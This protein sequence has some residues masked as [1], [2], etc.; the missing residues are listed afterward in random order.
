MDDSGAQQLTSYV[1]EQVLA[2]RRHVLETLLHDDFI[3][4]G[5]R[6][7]LDRDE[8]IQRMLDESEFERIDTR[9]LD[10]FVHS[11]MAVVTAAVTYTGTQLAERLY[12]EWLIADV[13]QRRGVDWQLISRTML[14]SANV[15][16]TN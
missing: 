9:P 13:W 3:L 5:V 2:G 1:Y 16:P 11:A 12:G 8:W 7:H 4:A 6:D 15:G 10:A 14:P